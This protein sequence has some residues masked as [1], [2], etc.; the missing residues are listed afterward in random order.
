MGGPLNRDCPKPT[1]DE[2]TTLSVW[3]ACEKARR[4]AGG[5]LR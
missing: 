2:R 4:A 3:L 5:A 1:T